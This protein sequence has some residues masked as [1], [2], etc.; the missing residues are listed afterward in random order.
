MHGSQFWKQRPTPMV[1]DKLNDMR[2]FWFTS[3]P[4]H[5]LGVNPSLFSLP[6]SN[7][8]S[9]KSVGVVGNKQENWNHFEVLVSYQYSHA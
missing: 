6:S 8:K 5:L 9:A 4:K 3:E 2:L 7:W 1:I